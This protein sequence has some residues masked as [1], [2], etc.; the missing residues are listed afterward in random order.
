VGKALV[1]HPATA[2]VGFTG[3]FTG[4]KAL[5]DLANQR[6]R[7]IPVFAEMSSINPVVF[8]PDTLQQNAATL[9][10]AYAGSITLGVG[11]FCTNPG[12]LLAIKS[13]ALDH[14]LALLGKEIEQVVPQKMLHSGIQQSYVKGLQQ[15]LAQKGIDKVGAAVAEAGEGEALP[16]VAKVAAKDFLKNPHLREEIFG[17]YSLAVVCDDKAALAEVLSSLKG[18][19]T[20][21][22]MAT[23]KDIADHADI[24]ALQATLAGRIILNDVPT[25]VEVCASMVHGGP[26][27]STTDG[28]YTS[29]GT[30]AIKRWVRPV[31]FQNFK[32]NMLPAELK[33]SNPP[34]I[35]R[36][37]N[38]EWTKNA[39]V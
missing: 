28:R 5:W 2:G 25:G 39:I 6:E 31:C 35:W 27:P 24:I 30:T 33:N 10:K 21:T 7:P 22:V 36:I 15:A 26:Y 34:G 19:L 18:Q 17:P 29:V 37:V 23:D 1:Q 8:L 3:S 20:T 14:F 4:G 38:N 16:T 12:I 32:D 9:A 11:Q 13:E